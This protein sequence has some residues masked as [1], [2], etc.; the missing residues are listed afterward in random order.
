[1][2]TGPLQLLSAG[3]WQELLKAATGRRRDSPLRPLSLQ[4]LCPHLLG[5]IALQGRGVRT[6]VLPQ[7]WG[8]LG[9]CTG[10]TSQ[11]C[12]PLHMVTRL[13]GLRHTM[14]QLGSGG[15]N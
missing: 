3:R 11:S 9:W 8:S 13:R 5:T 4:V 14:A 10:K 1:M 15:L 7:E 6:D 12:V 2:G